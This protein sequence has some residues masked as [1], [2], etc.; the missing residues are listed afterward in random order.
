MNRI[1]KPG[2]IAV[3]LAMLFA[4]CAP[5]PTAAPAAPTQPPAGAPRLRSMPCAK[6]SRAW[7]TVSVVRT[8]GPRRAHGRD[9]MHAPP[10]ACKMCEAGMNL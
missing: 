5:A 1:Y 8:A 10:G 7:R 6:A 9:A 3:L 2:L 4:A